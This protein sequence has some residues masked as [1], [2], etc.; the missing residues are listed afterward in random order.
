MNLVHGTKNE[1]E[2]KLKIK[3]DRMIVHEGS[4]GEEVKLWGWGF[5]KEVGEMFNASD[6]LWQKTLQFHSFCKKIIC[7][8][9]SNIML[10]VLYC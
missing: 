5:V 10:S 3:T 1:K 7:L 8:H 9:G 4:P 6:M 2:K